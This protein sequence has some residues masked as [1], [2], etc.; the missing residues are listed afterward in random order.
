MRENSHEAN[1]ARHFT[2]ARRDQRAGCAAAAG[3]KYPCRQPRRAHGPC[4]ILLCGRWRP[5]LEFQHVARSSST[6]PCQ[7]ASSRSICA[8][9]LPKWVALSVSL[10]TPDAL[11]TCRN[12]Q[13]SLLTD[14]VCLQILQAAAGPNVGHLA[15]CHCRDILQAF[16]ADSRTSTDTSGGLL[17]DLGG[18]PEASLVV[19]RGRGPAARSMKI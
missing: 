7:S 8:A 4:P 16:A 17:C 12:C 1:P 15:S 3:F 2:R 10:V 5:L 18:C 19:V 6:Q 9:R 11:A 14:L 13:P